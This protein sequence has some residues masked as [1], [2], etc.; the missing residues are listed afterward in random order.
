MSVLT[1]LDQI[2]SYLSMPGQMFELVDVDIRGHALPV[3]RNL[4]ANLTQFVVEARVH[5]DRDFLVDGETRL[6]YRETL[7]RAAGLARVLGTRYGAGD[8]VRVAIASRNSPEWVIAFLA[9]L[10]SGATAALVNSRGT[11]DDMLYALH[12]TECAILIADDRRAEALAATADGGFGGAIIVAGADGAFR[13]AAGATLDIAGAEPAPSAALP[14]DPAVI[15]FTSG[16]TGRPK[17]AVLTHRGVGMFLYGMRHNGATYIAHM[18]RMLRMEPSVLIANLP[19]PATLAIFP[20]FHVSGA[21]AMLMGALITGGKMVFLNRWDPARAL[22][23]IAAERITMFQGPPSIFWDILNCP[24]FASAEIGSITNIGIGGQATP[25]NLLTQLLKAFPRAAPGGGY[26]M[27]ETNGAVASATGAEYMACPGASGRVLPGS[28]LAI[29]DEDGHDLP[30]GTAGEIW[31]K[32]PLVMA[33]YWNQPEANSASFQDGWFRTGDV[34][35]LDENRFITV[36]DRKKDVVIRGGE[37]IYCAEL[38]RIFADFPGVLEVAAFGVVDERWGERV[39]LAAVPHHGHSLDAAEIL[40]FGRG[41]LADYKIP[42]EIFI[43]PEPFA[44][45][46]VG[47]V[48]KLA[49]RRQ[50]DSTTH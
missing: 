36:V 44:R 31:V 46:A 5:A 3:Y 34:G 21:S 47:K 35:F 24:E 43:A 16:T 49:L 9:I 27:T 18:A 14:D 32:S 33:G 19:Q 39:V 41:R 25:P 48:D 17:G 22:A 45:N 15:M 6:T 26:G 40:A 23:L 50:F 2:R 10:L 42:S 30:L 13:D 38:E 29:R 37:N 12:D 4:P 7:A 11:P 1:E 20:L 8:N 28:E